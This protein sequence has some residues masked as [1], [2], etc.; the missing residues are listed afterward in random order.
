MGGLFSPQESSSQDDDNV[1]DDGE[2]VPTQDTPETDP[3]S[4][5]RMVVDDNENPF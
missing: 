3:A 1:S 4:S 5:T 2:V